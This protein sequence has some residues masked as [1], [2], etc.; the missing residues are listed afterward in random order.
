MNF[1]KKWGAGVL[2][3]P[4]FACLLAAG[5]GSVRITPIS[6]DHLVPKPSGFEV[7]LFENKVQQP[8]REIAW[9]DSRALPDP[10]PEQK[11]LQL[12]QIQDAARKLGAD[13]VHD[14]RP[15]DLRVKGIV[16]DER[17]PFNAFKQG[18]YTLRFWRGTAI[19]YQTAAEA[20][21]A[22]ATGA[23]QLLA[24]ASPAP[25]DVSQPSTAA[26]AKSQP[27][28]SASSDASSSAAADGAKKAE[29]KPQ[30]APT[31]AP[32]PPTLAPL[33]TISPLSPLERT[34]APSPTPSASPSPAPAA[35]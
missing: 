14:M 11:E 22:G 34:P 4:A 33:P 17:V 21:A 6:G 23:A 5:C 19:V 12:R 32:L 24:P 9:I 29:E 7:K 15:L 27:V 25:S 3:V 1:A 10:S 30:P 13:A 2:L 8:H 20:S 26:P 28:S 16:M 35:R 31:P 18:E